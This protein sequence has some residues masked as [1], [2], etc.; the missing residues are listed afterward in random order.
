MGLKDTVYAVANDNAAG[1][2]FDMHVASTSVDGFDEN[3]IDEANNGCFL[4]L[5]TEFTSVSFK[6]LEQLD[7]V[8]LIA[9]RSHESF[10]GFTTDPQVLFNKLGDLDLLGNHRNHSAA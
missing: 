1:L 3:F 6:L 2:R 5:L 10:D 9:A 8:V 7:I 4:R